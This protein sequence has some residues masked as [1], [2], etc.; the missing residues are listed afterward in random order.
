MLPFTINKN[1]TGGTSDTENTATAGHVLR[2]RGLMEVA[3]A[4]FLATN[5]DDFRRTALE[6]RWDSLLQYVHRNLGAN[7]RIADI[8][9]QLGSSSN[10]PLQAP[11][12]TSACHSRLGSPTALLAAGGHPTTSAELR[13]HEIADQLRFSSEFHFSRF[14]KHNTGQSLTAYREKPG[15]IKP[16]PKRQGCPRSGEP[17]D[18]C[19]QAKENHADAPDVGEAHERALLDMV[20][21]GSQSFQMDQSLVGVEQH[22]PCWP[23]HWPS[24]VHSRPEVKAKLSSARCA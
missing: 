11:A 9:D 5:A 10:R 20:N 3:L 15:A 12:A 8:A 23:F 13:I 14:F 2:L 7:L 24:A 4:P 16:P 17:C 21:A 6:A 18:F 19:F 22:M 1:S